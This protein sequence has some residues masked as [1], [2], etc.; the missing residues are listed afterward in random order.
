MAEFFTPKK[1]TNDLWYKEPWM[2][3]VIGGPAIVVIAALVTVY[4][5]WHG[6]DQVVSK[7]Y[8]K[9]GIN[10]NKE[11]YRD[12]RAGEYRMLA[13]VQLDGTTGK[14]SLQL[15]GDTMMPSSV[16]LSISST[17]SHSEFEAIQKIVLSQ[18]KTGSY[19]GLV[20]IPATP[21]A[22]NFNLWHIQLE[23]NDWRLTGDWHNPLHAA[24]QLKP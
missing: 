11:I 15:K 12:A 19:E 7:D 9:Q 14:I 21:N 16:L 5:A 20:T 17:A 4:I 1:T 22:M 13:R 10:I 23:A 24:I 6:A 18:I 3:L 2:L 8:Y